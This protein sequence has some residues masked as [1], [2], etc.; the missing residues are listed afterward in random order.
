MRVERPPQVGFEFEHATAASCRVFGLGVPLLPIA[1]EFGF[2]CARDIGP[3]FFTRTGDERGK[4]DPVVSGDAQ[5]VRDLVVHSGAT[6][7]VRRIRTSVVVLMS[8]TAFTPFCPLTGVSRTVCRGLCLLCQFNQRVSCSVVRGL[9]VVAITPER[10][11]DEQVTQRHTCCRLGHQHAFI[12]HVGDGRGAVHWQFVS[13]ELPK[14]WL[15]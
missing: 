3:R 12:N 1:I 4:R 10:L 9:F 7:K 2:D 15:P 13:I 11:D 14:P 6:D 8:G 5:A